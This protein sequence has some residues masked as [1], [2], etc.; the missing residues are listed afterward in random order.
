[1]TLAVIQM[2]SQSDVLANLA[3]ARRLLEEAAQGGAQ[4]AVLPEN[5]AAMGRRDTAAIG[6]AE[7]LG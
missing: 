1:M 2:V 6:R 3:Q 7:A 5:F 4:L